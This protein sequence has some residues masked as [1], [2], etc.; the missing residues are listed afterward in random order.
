MVLNTIAEEG[1]AKTQRRN[2]PNSRTHSEANFERMKQDGEKM[3]SK[4]NKN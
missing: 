3:K 1:A 4:R 2:L